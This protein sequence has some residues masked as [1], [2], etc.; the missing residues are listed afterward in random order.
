MFRL[1]GAKACTP[2]H[3]IS[4]AHSAVKSFAIFRSCSHCS[5]TRRSSTCSWWYRYRSRLNLESFL[6]IRTPNKIGLTASST[7]GVN[8]LFAMNYNY[9]I[10]ASENAGGSEYLTMSD[11]KLMSQCEM[12]TFKSS[13]PGGQ[14]RNKRE[15][16]VRLKHLPTGIIAQAAEDR[17]QHKNRAA[18]LIRLRTLLALKIRNAIDLDGYVPPPEL[19]QILPAN[20]TMRGS[21]K[22][23]QI[24]PNNPKFIL[25][26]Q[27]LL[28]LIFAVEGSVSDAAKKLGLSTG[29]L[30]RLILSDDSLRAAANEFRA[31][32]GLKPLK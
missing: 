6:S 20:S 4:M 12:D 13:G 10:S 31:T 8:A 14:H 5:L 22:G 27:A 19:V 7:I 26:M 11:E 15:S 1:Q 17:S 18:A 16:A 23:P 3:G 2:L 25:G 30:S 21:Y 32:K 24:G 28:D 9:S 29:A